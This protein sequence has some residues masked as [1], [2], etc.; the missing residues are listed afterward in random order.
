MATRQCCERTLVCE[1]FSLGWLSRCRLPIFFSRVVSR[2]EWEGRGEGG[3]AC[4]LFFFFPCREVPADVIPV[5]AFLNRQHVAL[6][7]PSVS[8]SGFFRPTETI[9]TVCIYGATTVP[10]HHCI[11]S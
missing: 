7:P 10:V 5:D 4:D 1:W 11:D 8:P 3:R 6:P 9:G 2:N